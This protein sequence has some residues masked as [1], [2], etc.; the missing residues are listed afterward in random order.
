MEAQIAFPQLVQR[1][2]QPRLVVDPPPY[3]PSPVLRG[4]EH[5]LIEVDGVRASPEPLAPAMQR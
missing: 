1:L 3:R 5:L 4:P 2:E